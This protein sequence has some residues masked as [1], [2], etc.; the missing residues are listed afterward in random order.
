MNIPE[1]IRRM[2]LEAR[3]AARKLGTL[4][5]GVKNQVILRVAALLTGFTLP[6]WSSGDAA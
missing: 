5:S 6:R 4:S 1:T 2:A 3:Q